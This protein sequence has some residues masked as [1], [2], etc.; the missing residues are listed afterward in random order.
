MR[1]DNFI[2]GLSLPARTDCPNCGNK[3]TFS[4]R[5]Y[6]G[7]VLYKCFH[8]Q[9]KLR[10]ILNV[11]ISIDSIL[12]ISKEKEKKEWV[13]PEYFCSP[14]QNSECLSFLKR[15]NL[16]D[17]YVDGLELYYDHRQGRCVFPLRD[18][19]GVLKGATGRSLDFR[20]NPRWYIYHRNSMCP[21]IMD[22]RLQNCTTILVEDCISAINVSMVSSSIALLGTNAPIDMFTYFLPYDR[23]VIAL[24]A[25]ATHKSIKLQKE[26]S[27]IKPTS[28]LVLK[29]DL[30]YLKKEEMEE[31]LCK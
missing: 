13:L 21:Y 27:I 22:K 3:N 16:L 23:L 1:F 14:L 29:K 7:N 4:A 9:C 30:K 6:D 18:H 19:Q 26:L 25:D 2:K 15:W 24:D 31:L 17:K 10:G 8:A 20:I 28:I 11:G 5:L 12:D